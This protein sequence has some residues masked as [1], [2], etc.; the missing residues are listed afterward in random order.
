MITNLNVNYPNT[1]FG[2]RFQTQ[3]VLG[4]VFAPKSEE[5]SSFFDKRLC[6]EDG[7]EKV[8]KAFFTHFPDLAETLERWFTK[9]KEEDRRVIK[10][11]KDA[12]ARTI[13]VVMEKFNLGSTIDI[14]V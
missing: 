11:D 5:A 14:N 8:V 6:T 10:T 2:M 7:A 9:L 3:K 4:A 1:S 13:D 12:L